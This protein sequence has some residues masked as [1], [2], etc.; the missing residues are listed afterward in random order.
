LIK[1]PVG[2]LMVGQD[3]GP[4]PG[5]AHIDIRHPSRHPSAR[6][7]SGGRI[8]ARSVSMTDRTRST[9][10]VRRPEAV[11]ASRYQVPPLAA[12]P[13][14]STV[15]AVTAPERPAYRNRTWTRSMMARWSTFR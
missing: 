15:R 14:G 11:S 1:Q 12:T 6:S 3:H 9:L 7:K 4:N 13:S 2:R 5:A 8:A 10:K